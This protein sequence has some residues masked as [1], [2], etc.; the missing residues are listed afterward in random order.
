M[1]RQACR[2]RYPL[3]ISLTSIPPQ[4]NSEQRIATSVTA[5]TRLTT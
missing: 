3:M 2:D 1:I 4:A 5:R